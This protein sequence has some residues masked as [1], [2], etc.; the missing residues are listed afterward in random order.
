MKA[1]EIRSYFNNDAEMYIFI[2]VH[3]D[4]KRRMKYL[5]SNDELYEDREVATKWFD[6]I[7]SRIEHCNHS[8]TKKAICKLKDIYSNMTDYNDVD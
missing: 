3:M 6:N 8:D 7:L 2:L 5:N 4:G 1:D